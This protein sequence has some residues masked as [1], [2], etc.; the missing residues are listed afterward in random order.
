MERSARFLDNVQ[1]LWPHNGVADEQREALDREEFYRITI[2][3]KKFVST[4]PKLAY[5]P[6]FA[7]IVIDEE[8]GYWVLGA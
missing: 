8:S 7:S 1:A 4:G 5:A 6:P 3:G 2:D